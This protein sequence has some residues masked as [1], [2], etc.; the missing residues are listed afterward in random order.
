MSR[1]QPA[2][3][4][5]ASI[6]IGG[7]T[8]EAGQVR[9]L[10]LPVARLVTQAWLTLPVSVVHG[11]RP[12]PRIWLSA[13]VHGDEINGV[14]IIRQVLARMDA[15]TL[16][17]TVIAVPI[18]NVFG[19]INESRYL[20]D[21]RDLNR[22]F[23]GSSKGSLAARLA[24]LFL[25][26]VVNGCTHGIDLHTGADERSNYPHVRANL[27]DPE[28]LRCAK[29]FG[30]PVLMHSKIRDGSLRGCASEMGIPVLVYEAGQPRRYDAWAIRT[31]VRGV[32]RVL[33]ALGM[34]G[35]APRASRR[36]EICDGSNWVRARRSGLCR[37]QAELGDR[38]K[39]RQ[40]LGVIADA[41]GEREVYVRAS[42]AGTIIGLAQ[43]PLVTRGDAVAHIAYRQE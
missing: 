12:G 21:R 32:L 38:V 14:E 31:G 42:V 5:S 37:L 11:L 15:R 39:E 29:A 34:R 26:E 18:V 16:R 8:I 7:Q 28:T 1:A 6:T 23:P 25:R 24:D 4:R 27:K 36:V 3:E 2:A 33:A 41:F 9:R 22:S 35:A 10:E 43:N 20:P 17:G 19:F 30:A 40:I 13:A